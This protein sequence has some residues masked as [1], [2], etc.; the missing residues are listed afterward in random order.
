MRRRGALALLLL[1]ALPAHAQQRGRGLQKPPP[2]RL[3]KEAAMPQP[4]KSGSLANSTVAPVPDR[5]QEAPRVIPQERARINPG[6]INRDLPGRGLNEQGA[7]NMLED[8]LFRP[9][10]GVRL[11]APFSY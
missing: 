4:L 3:E 5:N 7:P 10:P 2:L 11:N 8:K 1:A 9:A 6:V